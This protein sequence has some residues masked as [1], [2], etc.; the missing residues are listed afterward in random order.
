MKTRFLFIFLFKNTAF[1]RKVYIYQKEWLKNSYFKWE[2]I[3]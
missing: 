2:V 1:F 3:Y